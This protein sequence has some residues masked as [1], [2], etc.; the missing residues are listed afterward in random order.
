MGPHIYSSWDHWLS[1]LFAPCQ[2]GQC[3]EDL[4]Y[5]ERFKLL[6]ASSSGVAE[7]DYKQL[8]IVGSEL[9]EKESKDLR[10]ASY[11]LL[12]A[13]SE[14]GIQGLIYSLS[15]I[16]QLVNK[17]SAEMFPVKERPRKAVH[18]WLLQQQDR[19]KGICEQ[20]EDIKPEDW[21]ALKEQIEVYKNETLIALDDSAGPL[22]TLHDWVELGCK[23]NPV[24]TAAEKLN[25]SHEAKQAHSDKTDKSTDGV[26]PLS[27]T[28]QHKTKKDDAT[29]SNSNVSEISLP[30]ASEVGS[31][32][33]Y[34]SLI[35]TLIQH[36]K[37]KALYQ[38]MMQLS[39][40]YRWGSLAVPPHDEQ[41]KTRVP[42][43]RETAFAPI[44]HAK[45]NGNFEQGFLLAEA[46]F[47][48]GAMQF[49]LDLQ[50]LT[51]GLLK[52]MQKQSLGEWLT[53]Q[54]KYLITAYPEITKLKYD[55][56]LAFASAKTIAWLDELKDADNAANTAVVENDPFQKIEQDAFVLADENKLSD[57]L[58]LLSSVP[59]K[60]FF[61]DAKLQLLRAKLLLRNE[62]Y[63]LAKPLF[64]QLLDHIEQYD[65][66]RWHQDFVMQVWRF[67]LRCFSSL[68]QQEG[69]AFY[70]RAKTIETRMLVTDT[71]SAIT[72]L[73]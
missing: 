62:Q 69:D 49:N 36:D 54:V 23:Q 51:V 43:P 18:S 2:T 59:A 5:D 24:N 66:A 19:L 30:S 20:S 70:R 37:E 7:Q 60:T 38:R 41:G 32:S 8:F 67:A 61:D 55:N 57:A 39:R 48:E 65:L 16:N 3:G 10:I 4:I 47:M 56:G 1:S 42:A 45:Q 40:A 53:A 46:V 15:L 50:H 44:E 35:R 26:K 29:V 6:K 34:A 33:Q 13:T 27:E 71:A 21:R 14:F 68:S 22:A 25:L 17:H 28:Q 52:S 63:A 12:V 64:E 31:D 58:Q 73:S 72:W 9:F 11:L